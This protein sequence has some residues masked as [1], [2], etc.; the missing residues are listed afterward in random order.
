MEILRALKTRAFALLI[1]VLGLP[2]CLPMP[3][4]I[5]LVCG[6][7]LL[8]VSIQ[9][10]AGLEVPWFPARIARQSV[11]R[12]DIKGA[13]ARSLPVVLRLERLSR[14]RL[15][16]FDGKLASRMVGVVLLIL[17]L[18]LILAAP[19]VGQIPMGVAICLVGLGLVERDGVI[20]LVGV[21]VGLFG[22]TLSV[23]F[24]LT[25]ITGIGH[26]LG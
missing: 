21:L 2:N 9:M 11:A 23:G 12:N 13:V 26:L 25:L 1:V 5:P 14:Q 24:V 7:L 10:I 19:F 15:I 4:P 17:S 6:F 18:G 3:P 20:F 22:L 16:F 8:A